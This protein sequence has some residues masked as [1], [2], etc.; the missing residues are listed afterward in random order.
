MRKAETILEVI[1]KRGQMGQ[2]LERVY[3]LLFN[4]DLYLKG[5]S[6]MYSNQG[7]LTKGVN[8]D[9]VDGM[10]EKRIE[11]IIEKL[12]R[13]QYNFSPARRTYIEKANSNKNCCL[14]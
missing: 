3:R 6:E 7:A 9:T 2:P 13:E 14:D 10:S 11:E 12:R 8:E 4:P 1:H 5:Y